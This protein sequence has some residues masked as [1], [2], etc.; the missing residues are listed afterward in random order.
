MAPIVPKR[1]KPAG[2]ARWIERTVHLPQGL[3]AEPGRVKLWPWQRGIAA[4]IGDAHK[5]SQPRLGRGY[6][7]QTIM[8]AAPIRNGREIGR[9]GKVILNWTARKPII[10]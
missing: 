8:V 3:A 1:R 4:A 9:C 7:D 2:L 10:A 5:V 6:M